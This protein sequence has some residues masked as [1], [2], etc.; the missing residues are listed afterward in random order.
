MTVLPILFLLAANGPE[1]A[2]N[3]DLEQL[4][5]GYFT[6][7]SRGWCRDGAEHFRAEP[8]T[9]QPHSGEY[10]LHFEHTGERDWA[11]YPGVPLDV[12]EGD[13]F[14]LS[15]WVRIPGA[16]HVMLCASV[17][18]PGAGEEGVQWAAGGVVANGPR[19][20]WRRLATTV[21]IA[22]GMVR[23]LPRLIG[24]GP[25]EAWVDDFSVRFRGNLR[26][27]RAAYRGAA[28]G[29]LDGRIL[30][31][32][33]QATDAALTVTDQRTSRVYHSVGLPSLVPTK[34]QALP[35]ALAVEAQE[36]VADRA[37]HLRY[38]LEP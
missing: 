17:H 6:D 8:S 30:Q 2:P 38:A 13:V 15:V 5:D 37:L 9:D 18:P 31:V 23:A 29:M 7:W 22:P 28:Q 32:A 35:P 1:L 34:V 24:H 11:I 36:L 25:V 12:Q 16:G 21:V 14:D 4:A 20:D 10:C 27:L 26:E 3:G 19:A 33:V